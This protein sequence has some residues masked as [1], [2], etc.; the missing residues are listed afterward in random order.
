MCRTTRPGSYAV[1][2]QPARRLPYPCLRGMGRPLFRIGIARAEGSY[3]N[4]TKVVYRE[5]CFHL[6]HAGALGDVCWEVAPLRQGPSH[7]CRDLIHLHCRSSY[8]TFVRIASLAPGP[9]TEVICGGVH[10]WYLSFYEVMQSAIGRPLQYFRTAATST[11][12][13]TEL[14]ERVKGPIYLGTRL[15]NDL[16]IERRW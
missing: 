5:A 9:E 14:L 15:A 2:L 16:D 13:K 11:K 4:L 1:R 3:S 10:A 6:Y 12:T 7:Y 8:S